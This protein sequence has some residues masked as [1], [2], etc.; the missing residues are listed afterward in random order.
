MNPVGPNYPAEAAL[1]LERLNIQHELAKFLTTVSLEVK[2][3][4]R[5][6]PND[7]ALVKPEIK[8]KVSVHRVKKSAHGGAADDDDSGKTRDGA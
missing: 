8:R 7:Q 1:G 4:L 3:E 5:F 6:I 2:T